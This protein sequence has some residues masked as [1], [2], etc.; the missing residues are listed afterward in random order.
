M[1]RVA[2]RLH[3]KETS[4]G[5]GFNI[6]YWNSKHNDS[7]AFVFPPV[8]ALKYNAEED[9]DRRIETDTQTHPPNHVSMT[10]D[11]VKCCAPH[12]AAAA[13]D[14][15]PPIPALMKHKNV[16]FEQ[17]NNKMAKRQEQLRARSLQQTISLQHH[18]TSDICSKP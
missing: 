13:S 4:K 17:R 7:S 9:T 2:V 15:I 14:S 16:M 12:A 1:F 18:V 8:T 5:S 10:G 3:L 6:G 11:D